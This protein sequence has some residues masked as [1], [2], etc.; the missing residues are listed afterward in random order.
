LAYDSGKLA[1][2]TRKKLPVIS[3]RGMGCLKIVHKFNTQKAFK[4]FWTTH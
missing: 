4:K 3:A 2:A 1:G